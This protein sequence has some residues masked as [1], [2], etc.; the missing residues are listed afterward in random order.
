MISL[1]ALYDRILPVSDI[2]LGV[3]IVSYL[4]GLSWHYIFFYHVCYYQST[5]KHLLPT[6]VVLYLFGLRWLHISFYHSCYYQSSP[7]HLLITLTY[8][9]KTPVGLQIFMC[10]GLFVMNGIPICENVFFIPI[11]SW[12]RCRNF[13]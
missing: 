11:D 4:F 8:T 9:Q 3:P 10:R 1:K 13:L 6:L 12:S 2:H 7:K 5:P